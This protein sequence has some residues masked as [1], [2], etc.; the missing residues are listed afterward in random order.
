MMN[1]L[2]HMKEIKKPKDLEETLI[3]LKDFINALSKAVQS[4]MDHKAASISIIN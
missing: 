1:V 4:P 3:R 2:V